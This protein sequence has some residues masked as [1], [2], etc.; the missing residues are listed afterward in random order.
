MLEKIRDI[1]KDY[2]EVPAEKITPQ[3]H[4]RDDLGLNSLDVVNVVVAFEDEFDIEIDDDDISS[5][6]RVED[7]IRY[8][9]E[10]CR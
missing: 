5:M 1:L 4:F 7:A 6:V 9:T 3:S 2:T 8:I 10:R